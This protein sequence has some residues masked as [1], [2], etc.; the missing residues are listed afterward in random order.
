M[1]PSP[2]RLKL[3]AGLF[4]VMFVVLWGIAILGLVW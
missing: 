1:T 3:V 2:P 4:V